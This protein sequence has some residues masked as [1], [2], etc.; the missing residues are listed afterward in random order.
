MKRILILGKTGMLGH[1]VFDYF[2]QLNEHKIIGI[3]RKQINALD[4]ND[5]KIEKIILN[6]KPDIIIN[7][8]GLINKCITDE[9]SAKKI[10]GIFPHYLAYL[11]IKHN[12]KLIHI[13]SDCVLDKDTYGKSKLLGEI[14]DNHNLTIRTSIIGPELKDGFGLFHWFM[15]QKNEARGY[16]N[17]LWDGVTT[18][19]LSKFIHECINKKIYGLINYRTKDSINKYE[20]LKIISKI[21][22]KKINIIPDYTIIKDKR[23]LNSEYWCEKTYDEQLIDLKEF[24]DNKKIYNIYY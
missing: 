24:C 21:F 13:S 15:N 4:F 3:T 18:L 12:F 20:L 2:K 7:C 10:N 16:A 17:V 23:N 14:N 1:M 6:Y 8:I 22:N 5:L 19:E 11:G 9:K